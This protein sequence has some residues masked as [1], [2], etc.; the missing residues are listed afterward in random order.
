MTLAAPETTKG[1]VLR[2]LRDAISSLKETTATCCNAIQENS[3]LHEAFL[4]VSRHL[5]CLLNTFTTIETHLK[6]QTEEI[7]EIKEMYPDIRLVA[8]EYRNPVRSIED[9]F[10]SVKG[11]K[12]EE[13]T[14]R[15]RAAVQECNDRKVEG[16]MLDLLERAI[17][18]AQAPL[19]SDEQIEQLRN[20]LAEIR[21]LPPSLEDVTTGGF[22][23]IN[24]GSGNQF[25][26][27]GKGSMNYS[28]GG[29][30]VTGDNHN[31]HYSYSAG[32]NSTTQS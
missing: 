9:L 18:I 30:M 12:G 19:V 16:V 8:D 14:K 28:S 11:V 20:A 31:A 10:E 3:D 5:P 4:V 1:Q 25:Y 27:G 17:D 21:K 23:M 32:P 15:Y 24:H 2:S 26:H 13:R 7:P 29:L 6:S 22:T